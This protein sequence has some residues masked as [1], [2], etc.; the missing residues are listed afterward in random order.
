MTKNHTKKNSKLLEL[1]MIESSQ[2]KYKP[3]CYMH[4][5]HGII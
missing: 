2:C 5:K 1:K 4:E 3:I